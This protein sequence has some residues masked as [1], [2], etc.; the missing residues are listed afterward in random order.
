[1]KKLIKHF[2]KNKIAN[3]EY[4]LPKI[5]LLFITFSFIHC[6]LG[7]QAKFIY[8]IGVV[9]FLVFINRVKFLYIS[10]V[11]IFT[12][13]S[14]IYLPIAILYGPPSFNILASLFYT[15]KDEAIGFLSLIPYYYY[16][17]SLLILFLGIFCSR[18]KIKKIKYLSSISFIIFFVILLS[19][20][21]KDYRKESS[22]NLLN[23]GYP[24]MKFIKEFYYSLIELNKENSKLE[25]LIY[26]KDDFNPVNSKNKYNTYVMVIG[27]S[28]R[29]DL[30]H[31]YGFHINNTPFMNS[32]NGIFFT[33]YISAGASTNISLSNTIAIKGNLSNNIVSLANK[34]GFSTYWLSNQGALGIFD[35]PIASMGKKANKYHFLKK[36]DYDNSNNSSNDTGL[37]PFIKTAINDN[38]KIS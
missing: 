34:A 26:Q 10:F 14:T 2:I 16:L 11:W 22:I 36:G 29:R 38:K 35:T 7:Y 17:F 33:N 28:A 19:T 37:L 18:L 25:K 27:E 8:T 24:E 6:G 13:I 4:F 23:S 5:I 20:P 30:M 32:I 12:I 9:A 31:F 15:N 21:I 3:N 1:M